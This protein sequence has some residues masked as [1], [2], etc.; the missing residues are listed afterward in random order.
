[1]KGD[2]SRDTFDK[3]KHF[4]R[5]LMQQG[6]VQ[7]DSDWNEQGAI[8]LHY[9]RTLAADLIGPFAGPAGDHQGFNIGNADTKFKDFPIGRGRY[10]VDGILCENDAL[11]VSYK[12]QKDFPNPPEEFEADKSYLVYLDVWERH[13]T[14]VED[15][16]IREKALGGPDTA[17]RA[18]LIWQVKLWDTANN[19]TPHPPYNVGQI[20]KNW[21]E[22][23]EQDQWQPPYL[24]CLKA[25]VKRPGVSNDP[26]LTAPDAKYRGTENHLYRVEIHQ[27]GYNKGATFKWSRDN[28]AIVTGCKLEGVEL[29]VNNARGFAPNQ[30]VELTNHE[31]ELRGEHGTLVKLLKVESDVLT[32]AV[33]PSSTVPIPQN[34]T[35]PTKARRWDQSEKGELEL[36][37][38]AVQVI[39]NGDDDWINLEDGIQIQFQPP[40]VDLNRYR[41]GDYWLIPA[42]VATGNIEWPVNVNDKGE[43]EHDKDGNTI[44]IAQPPHGIRHHYAPLAILTTKGEKWDPDDCRCEFTALNKCA[45]PSHGEDGMG[46]ASECPK[47]DG[48]GPPKASPIKKVV[49]PSKKSQRK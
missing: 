36:N 20:H 21:K 48:S 14:V 42:R 12:N 4:S 3:A 41:T 11:G 17:S 7:L 9:L 5:V 43:L 28:G 26:C 39:E 18:Q 19:G 33:T 34:E 13:I 30:W 25:R 47:E 2:F 46:G 24:G 32:L 23:I 38:G 45:I 35:W 8:L 22:W 27:G 31:Q 29:T 6:R 49:Q 37:E 40:P 15:D 10:Y 1:M 44:P 16:F